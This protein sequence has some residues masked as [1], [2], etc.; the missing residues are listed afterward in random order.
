MPS[1]RDINS[2]QEIRK[3]KSLVYGPN[4]GDKNDDKTDY[5]S[6]LVRGGSY[7]I[8]GTSDNR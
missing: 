4:H 2:P 1:K 3:W 6:Q 7:R 5:T 8:K